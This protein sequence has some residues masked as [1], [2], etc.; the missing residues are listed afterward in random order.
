MYYLADQRLKVAAERF[1]ADKALRCRTVYQIYK[2]Y[3]QGLVTQKVG[4][5]AA[6]IL[7]KECPRELLELV[8][9][10]VD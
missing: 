8:A 3:K 10:T 5:K 9:P 1:S 4:E 6:E 2:L 7:E